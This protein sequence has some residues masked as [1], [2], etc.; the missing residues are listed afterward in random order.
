[1]RLG[2]WPCVLEAGSKAEEAYG[3]RKISERHR[4]RYEVN[5]KY[6]AQLDEKGLALCGLSPDGNL[7]EMVE[8]KDHPWF[9]CTQFHPEL[10]STPLNPHP[11][12][13]AFVGAAVG[14]TA[15]KA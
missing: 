14:R 12:F 1:M 15:L 7:V 2:A 8:V 3:T 10:K 4:H 13:A 9:V 5:N 6:R 11:L